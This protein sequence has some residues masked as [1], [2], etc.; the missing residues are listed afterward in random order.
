MLSEAE[1]WRDIKWAPAYQVSSLGRVR[2]RCKPGPKNSTR[3]PRLYATWSILDG[4]VTVYGYR[5]VI[6]DGQRKF[7][8]VLVADAF[9]GP[10]PLG[11]EV[12][13]K[14]ANKLNNRTENLEYVTRRENILHAIRLGLRPTPS[15][16]RCH[17]VV[18][19]DAEAVA[20]LRKVLSGK[21]CNAVAQ[22]CGLC[23]STVRNW[24]VGLTRPYL[25][26]RAKEPSCAD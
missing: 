21:S 7:A 5:S 9:L 18:T 14:D 23:T 26:Q 10:K 3:K 25:M 15:G 16:E 11:L 12:N 8:H 4:S 6:I 20:I 17:K 13:H 22:E 19:K 1:E 2:S 24:L